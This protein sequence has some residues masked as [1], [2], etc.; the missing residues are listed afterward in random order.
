MLVAVTSV[1]AGNSGVSMMMHVPS[2]G[3]CQ[4]SWGSM[5]VDFHPQGMPLGCRQVLWVLGA[6][7]LFNSYTW[8]VLC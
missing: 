3:F 6:P 8:L 4:L 1:C 5:V 2:S 7:F